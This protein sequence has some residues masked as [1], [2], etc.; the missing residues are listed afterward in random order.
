MP[1]DP[2][3]LRIRIYD[4]ILSRGGAPTSA[5]LAQ[6][7]GVEPDDARRALGRLKIGKTLLVS[8]ETGEIWMAGPFAAAET[9]YRIVGARTQWFANCA[10]D[11]LG[12]AQLVNEP[13]RIETRCTDCAEPMRLRVDPPGQPSGDGVVHFLV[14]ARRWYDDIGF[15]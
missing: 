3:A 12:V 14:P 10:W 11:M 5:D 8:P 13:V 7:F 6:S 1:I 4:W 15:T 2:R 9:P